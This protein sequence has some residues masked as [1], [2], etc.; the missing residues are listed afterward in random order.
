MTPKMMTPE[1]QQTRDAATQEELA[2]MFRTY[3]AV[4]ADKSMNR[5]NKIGYIMA[6]CAIDE[7]FRLGWMSF[8]YGVRQVT[9]AFDAAGIS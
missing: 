3:S 5:D 1:E 9:A 6:A 2:R 7:R 8:S 4:L